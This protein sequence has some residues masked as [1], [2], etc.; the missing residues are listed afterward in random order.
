MGGQ[1]QCYSKKKKKDNGSIRCNAAH[2]VYCVH[3]KSTLS[4]SI[5]VQHTV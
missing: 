5:H 2:T 1:A 4:A 3:I